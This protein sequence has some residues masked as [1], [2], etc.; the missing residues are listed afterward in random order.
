[1]NKSQ[2]KFVF[3][4]NKLKVLQNFLIGFGTIWLLIE[5]PSAIFE[6]FSNLIKEYDWWILS[7]TT[8]ISLI[9]GFYNAIPVTEMVR[10]FKSSNTSICIKVG[11]IF[12]ETN[13]IVVSSSDYFDTNY[14]PGKNISLKSQMIHKYFQNNISSLNTLIDTSLR[15]QGITGS[16]NPAKP[17]GKDI[18]YPIGTTAVIPV[19]QK[20]IFILVM[21]HIVYDNLTKHT[22]STPKDLNIALYSLWERIRTDGRM[23]EISLPVFGSGLG[24]LSLSRLM[25]I[26]SIIMS[27]A[28]HSKTTRISEKLNIIIPKEHYDPHDF[29]ELNK[30]LNSIQI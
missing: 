22:E 10:K 28:I 7:I 17:Q 8:I 16:V 24:G 30:F 18:K 14:S 29:E 9:F 21:T 20:R 27:F 5:F 19:Q 6:D 26:E 15:N 13:D 1:M 25:I 23:K 11:D 2:L 3:K 4:E 12:E